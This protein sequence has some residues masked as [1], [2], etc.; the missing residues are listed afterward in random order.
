MNEK[1]FALIFQQ[2]KSIAEGMSTRITASF[3][4]SPDEFTSFI[5][6]L[7]DEMQ[8]DRQS[9]ENK[10]WSAPLRSAAKY[11]TLHLTNKD[12]CDTKHGMEEWQFHELIIC[13]LT[14]IGIDSTGHPPVAA[15]LKDNKESI[16]SQPGREMV[17]KYITSHLPTHLVRAKF[18]A[19]AGDLLVDSDFICR[20]VVALGTVEATRRQVTDLIELRREIAKTT[21]A[22]TGAAHTPKHI[23]YSPPESPSC[24]EGEAAMPKFNS[25]V[26]TSDDHIDEFGLQSE[27]ANFNIDINAVQRDG[28]RRIIDE[29]YRLVDLTSNSADS[30]NMAICLSTVGEGLLKSRQPREAML[31]LEEAVG[32]YRSLLGPYHIDVARALNS[33]AK[34]LVR[35]G[36]SRVALLKF[37]EASRIYEACNAIRHYDSITNSQSMAN[38]LVDVGDWA[39]AEVTY[40]EVIELKRSVCGNNSVPVAKTINDYAVVL[41]K[42]GRTDDALRYYEEAKATYELVAKAGDSVSF[43]SQA[44]SGDIIGK[45]SFDVTLINL[46]IASIKSKKGDISGAITSYEEG[47]KGLKEYLKQQAELQGVEAVDNARVAS[48]RRHL[49][50]AIGRIGSL[51]LKQGDNDGALEAYASLLMAVE[52]SSP[53]AS[54]M[55]KA[56]AHVKCATIYRQRDNEKDN[57]HAIAHL[58]EALEMYTELHGSNHKDTQAIASSLRQWQSKD[59]GDDVY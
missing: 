48:T 27:N 25:T 23:V 29:V 34:A 28:S 46:N 10:S 51:K 7:E 22:R 14:G 40:D 30:L 21:A 59:A 43:L 17:E 57:E 56:K 38:L 18:L 12:P 24:A 41:A 36:E 39:K 19:S 53:V 55:E 1:V 20:R 37:A 6:E 11:L 42:H 47:V 5:N 9:N 58:R 45:C 31:R 13:A 50:S 8:R 4:P 15:F 16:I 2:I 54:R 52:E 35:L 32:V 44:E 26:N 3:A 33:V 49:V